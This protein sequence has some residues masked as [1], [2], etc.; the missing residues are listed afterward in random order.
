[1]TTID[2]YRQLHAGRTT[3]LIQGVECGAH[4]SPGEEHIIDENH[5][6]PGQIQWNGRRRNGVDWAQSD[7]IAKHGNIETPDGHGVRGIGLFIDSLSVDLLQGLHQALGDP[8]STGLQPDHNDAH[9]TMVPF[10][11]FVGYAGDGPTNI[12]IRKH[13][14]G[15]LL[16]NRTRGGIHQQHPVGP[17]PLHTG[18]ELL[19]GTAIQAFSLIIFPPFEPH[20]TRLT[21]GH[22]LAG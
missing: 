3:E 18:R 19:S 14:R 10:A 7:V 13:L 4:G 22:T 20:G 6:R 2:E 21:V 15:M 16:V 1:M 8:D 5:F 12:G 9:Q 17:A 11:D